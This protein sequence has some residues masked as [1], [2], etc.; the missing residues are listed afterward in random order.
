MLTLTFPTLLRQELPA[1]DHAYETIEPFRRLGAQIG[2]IHAAKLLADGKERLG[3]EAHDVVSLS[4]AVRFFGAHD[5][6]APKS[7]IGEALVRL[8][9][10]RGLL[11][12]KIPSGRFA[13]QCVFLALEHSMV[14][15][16]MVS[17]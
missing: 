7:P 14:H 3:A 9:G 4:R 16:L 12:P 15:W 8:P 10:R 5:R 1:L 11:L 17:G 13:Q 2:I 6:T